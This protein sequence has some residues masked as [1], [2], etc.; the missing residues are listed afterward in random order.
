LVGG[1]KVFIGAAFDFDTD[2]LHRLELIALWAA[3][4]LPSRGIEVVGEI[5]L[6]AAGVAEKWLGARTHALAVDEYLVV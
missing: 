4:T 1:E 5:A 6:Y 3:S 2:S